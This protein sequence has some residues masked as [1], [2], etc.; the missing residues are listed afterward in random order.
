MMSTEQTSTRYENQSLSLSVRRSSSTSRSRPW[1]CK[2]RSSSDP[3]AHSQPLVPRTL[4]WE[5]FSQRTFRLERQKTSVT[6]RLEAI[7]PTRSTTI[8]SCIQAH[9]HIFMYHIPHA[10]AAEYH[11]VLQICLH[12]S[13]YQSCTQSRPIN[14]SIIQAIQVN[15]IGQSSQSG[16]LYSHPRSQFCKPSSR[17]SFGLHCS[18][19]FS[20][21]LLPRGP[22]CHSYPS[23]F[24]W[25]HSIIHLRQNP[26]RISKQATS[27]QYSSH[28]NF[29]LF[30]VASS[31]I[32]FQAPSTFPSHDTNI[33]A[34]F[35]FFNQYSVPS[36]FE[37]L[38]SRSEYPSS[39]VQVCC[40]KIKSLGLQSC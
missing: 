26:S 38:Q 7:L 36:S 13:Q 10:I 1:G 17:Q 29:K 5:T 28:S 35:G 34:L 11:L 6:S 31:D 3:E 19:L 32:R 20:Y 23:H 2:S 33:Q 24:K 22:S 4:V 18:K 14:Q 30:L 12:S 27:P 21:S 8:N 15:R 37:F 25:T 40:G 16:Q 39:S 9:L